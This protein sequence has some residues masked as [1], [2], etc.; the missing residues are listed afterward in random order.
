MILIDKPYVSDF[1]IKTIKE[2]N[3]QIISTH[4][5]REMIPVDDL[6]WISE[7][8]ARNIFDNNPLTSVY[9]NSEN[10]ISWIENN[11]T[12]SN[13]PEQIQLF[14][15]KIKFRE[16]IQDSYPGYFFVGVKLNELK[17]L[18]NA[19]IKLPIIIKPAIGFFSLAV[20]KVDAV[21]QWVEVLKSI[22]N[23]I[24]QLKGIYPKEVVDITYFIIEEYIE[25]EE[26]AIDCYFDKK[27]KPIILNILHHIF[28]ST[29]DVSDRVYS[30]SKYIMEKYYEQIL[31]FLKIIGERT[32]LRNFPAHVEVRIDSTGIVIPIEVNPLRYGGL[33]TT[34]DISWYAYGINSYEYFLKNKTPN[35]KEIFRTRKN[36]KYSIIVLNNNSGFD[37]NEIEYFD[38]DLLLKNFKKP[39][40]LRKV[41]FKKYLVFG[42]LFI[43]TIIGNE[44]ELNQILSSDLRKYI[45]LKK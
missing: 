26:Y 14:K 24:E 43:E 12:S 37:E 6:N 2:K 13:L 11:F 7:K 18:N 9:T 32:N 10:S 15:N 17:N 28:S 16:L 19:D 3:F 1:L 44:E 27:G 35:W 25:G 5:A 42:F 33:C 23:E 31:N 34:G 38:Y 8:E 36:S 22:E 45:K 4:I 39:M 30:T 29:S 21:D 20:H 40:S 41:D